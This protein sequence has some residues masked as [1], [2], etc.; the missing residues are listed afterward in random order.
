M[1]ATRS[2]KPENAFVGMSGW[3]GWKRLAMNTEWFDDDF[4]EYNGA[5]CYELAL[6]GPRGRDLDIMYVGETAHE[7]TRIKQYAQNGSHLSDVIAK[8]LRKGWTL[9]Y[10]AQ[11]KSTKKKAKAMQD[12]QLADYSYPWNLQGQ[13]EDDE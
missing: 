13:T 5:A 1:E 3:T 4:D 9:W 8:E 11:A 6:A 2:F 10:R 7:K 12:R